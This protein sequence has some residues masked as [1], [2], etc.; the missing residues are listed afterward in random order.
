MNL[1]FPLSSAFLAL[2]LEDTAKWQ[3][4]AL[5][6]ELKDF[7]KILRFQN[8]NSPHL[9]LQF[10]KE[11]MEIEVDQILKQAEVIASKSE[12]FQLHMTHAET[13]GD[14]VLVLE[15]GFSEELARLKK[16]CPWPNLKSFKP[17]ITLARMRSPESFRVHKKKIMKLLKDISFDIPV[18][19]LRLYAEING[20]KQTPLQD[21]PF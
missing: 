10:W 8:P 12:P 15:I 11:L 6:E 9:T 2:P 21:F 13:F 7:E 17:H 18:D 5:Q 16:S 19:R 20:Q 3:F 14:R 1:S 4:Q